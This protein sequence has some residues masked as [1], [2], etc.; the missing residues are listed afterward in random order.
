MGCQCLE[1]SVLGRLRISVGSNGEIKIVNEEAGKNEEKKGEDSRIPS[2]VTKIPILIKSRQGRDGGVHDEQTTPSQSDGAAAPHA[3]ATAL[4]LHTASPDSLSSRQNWQEQSE[5]GNKTT[6]TTR[7]RTSESSGRPE[8]K[9]VLLNKAGQEEEEEEQVCEEVVSLLP[10]FQVWLPPPSPLLSCS[11]PSSPRPPLGKTVLKQRPQSQKSSVV[12]EEEGHEVRKT[13]EESATEEDSLEAASGGGDRKTSGSGVTTAEVQTEPVFIADRSSPLG[14]SHSSSKSSTRS[15]SRNDRRS[16]SSSPSTAAAAAA[17]N[18]GSQETEGEERGGVVVNTKDNNGLTEEE[19]EEEKKRKD[20]GKDTK[21]VVQEAYSSCQQSGIE[22]SNV[23]ATANTQVSAGRQGKSLSRQK[24]NNEGLKRITLSKIRSKTQSSSSSSSDSYGH[25][26]RNSKS[27]HIGSV[28]EQDT[29]TNTYNNV[30]AVREAAAEAEA[31]STLVSQAIAQV[32]KEK[33]RREE[34]EGKSGE[35]KDKEENRKTSSGHVLKTV[36]RTPSPT[37][38]V[39]EEVSVDDSHEDSSRQN[40]TGEGNAGRFTAAGSASQRRVVLC[41]AFTQTIPLA[42]SQQSAQTDQE[43]TDEEELETKNDTESTQKQTLTI[44]TATTE[45]CTTPTL[46]S[47]AECQTDPLEKELLVQDDLTARVLLEHVGTVFF[48]PDPRRAVNYLDLSKL[49]EEGETPASDE[50]WLAVEGEEG[51]HFEDKGFLSS[52]TEEEGDS[53]LE[54]IRRCYS[55]ETDKLSTAA[56]MAGHVT[57]AAPQPGTANSENEELVALAAARGSSAMNTS[58]QNAACSDV[59]AKLHG[60]LVE[61]LMPIHDTLATT[62]QNMAGLSEKFHQMESILASLCATVDQV[63]S[64]VATKAAASGTASPAPANGHATMV[65]SGTRRSSETTT[66]NQS[67]VLSRTSSS[68]SEHC[69]KNFKELMAKIENISVGISSEDVS[70]QLRDD[71]NQ[72]RKD[73]ELYR[74]REHGMLERMDAMEKTLLKLQTASPPQNS[75]FPS[76]S[77]SLEDPAPH[78]P[79]SRRG[80]VGS[81]DSASELPP[82]GNTKTRSKRS[83]SQNREAEEAESQM[84]AATAADFDGVTVTLSATAAKPPTVKAAL[85]SGG[86]KKLL[87]RRGSAENKLPKQQPV[88]GP[89]RQSRSPPSSRSAAIGLDSDT[90]QTDIQIARSDN[91][92]LRQDLQVF[93]EREVQLVRRNKELEDKLV[94]QRQKHRAAECGQEK[95]KKKKGEGEE[96]AVTQTK[97]AK[98]EFDINIDFTPPGKAIIID[99]SESSNKGEKDE[100]RNE[101]GEDGSGPGKKGSGEGE[102]GQKDETGEKEESQQMPAA[103]SDAAAAP[104]S[105]KLPVGKKASEDTSSKKGGGTGKSKPKTKPKPFDK[106]PVV[107]EK[108]PKPE[109]SA[110]LDR[111]NSKST[112]NLVTITEDDEVRK[113]SFEADDWRVTIK[114]KHDL[115]MVSRS[116]NTLVVTPKTPELKPKAPSPIVPKKAAPVM[117]AKPKPR[118]VPAPKP[119]RPVKVVRPPPSQPKGDPIPK[120]GNFPC[121]RPPRGYKPC[122]QN[123]YNGASR[124]TVGDLLQQPQQQQPQSY[125]PST[126]P[127]SEGGNGSGEVIQMYVKEGGI[128]EASSAAA[129]FG[130]PPPCSQQVLYRC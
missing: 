79:P 116:P 61:E 54:D 55:V 4:K 99:K 47:T 111:T 36:T 31:T 12:E 60:V 44:P 71:N 92:I 83:T 32:G 128:R 124:S 23:N 117:K 14:H 62:G 39:P 88:K 5:E 29:A 105:P 6:A 118:T 102:E 9:T 30:N 40:E 38:Q 94:L 53:D 100:R 68:A 123:N 18:N 15:N 114:S 115:E 22:E 63:K 129:N 97:V 84:V 7:R 127:S 82:I 122:R 34:E 113:A 78:R 8:S 35:K 80:S 85:Q 43:T 73:L 41:S 86:A 72:L 24:R 87:D 58:N 33:E 93:R 74:S 91:I 69:T 49:G 109:N 119:I 67:A 89:R 46:T 77:S 90:L 106:K 103:T 110:E 10:T 17:G 3:V 76:Q 64:E 27:S 11:C 51:G 108:T 1:H 70:K 26:S 130:E 20:Q 48:P 37:K 101:E 21:N 13:F 16:S 104:S 81:Q 52:T 2:R 56:T 107:V 96:L 57:A 95:E 50:I 125:H 42:V 25:G 98:A 75:C 59:A 19:E 121:P 45:T 66:K 120:P 112:P 28:S 126:S 65:P